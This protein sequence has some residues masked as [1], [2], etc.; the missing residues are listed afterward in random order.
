MPIFPNRIIIK[1]GLN[2]CLTV[3]RCNT[4]SFYNSS[5]QLLEEKCTKITGDIHTN[6]EVLVM[7]IELNN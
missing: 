6:Q 4:N 2:R 3:R 1:N 7:Y 5:V